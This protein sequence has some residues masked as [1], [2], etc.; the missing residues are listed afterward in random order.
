MN[1][2]AGLPTAVQTHV[3]VIV[4]GAANVMSFYQNGELLG[5]VSIT[6]NTLSALND[7]NNWLGR[8]QF[9]PDPEF[10]GSINEFRI[11]SAARTAAQVMASFTSGPDALPTQ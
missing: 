6:G 4:D 10:A 1:G 3:A 11:Y 8:S 9:S 5:Q 7:V 2:P